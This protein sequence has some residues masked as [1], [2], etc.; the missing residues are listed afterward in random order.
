MTIVYYALPV[1]VFASLRLLFGNCWWLGVDVVLTAFEWL[2]MWL[3]KDDM[4]KD[5]T[6]GVQLVGGYM[7]S[8]RC[9]L[10]WTEIVRTTEYV[11]TRSGKRVARERVHH[12]Y[13]DCSYTG[14]TSVGGSSRGIGEKHFNDIVKKWGVMRRYEV[15][16]GDNIAGGSRE[17]YWYDYRD[18]INTDKCS[19]Y[20]RMEPIVEHRY[21]ENKIKNSNSIFRFERI[22]KEKAKELGL[23]DFMS[24]SVD[25]VLAGEGEV[26]EDVQH[27]F[28]VF[29]SWYAPR[30]GMRLFVLI[31]DANVHKVDI[32]DKQRAWWQ[33]GN[34]NEFVV[35]LG[36]SGG[37]VKWCRPWSWSDEPTLEA[38]VETWFVKNPGYDLMAFLRWLKKNYTLWKPK[39][40][41][42]FDY[43][44][45]DLTPEQHLKLLL[46]AIAISLA[47]AVLYVWWLCS[48]NEW[49]LRSAFL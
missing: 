4:K 32:A 1:I 45:V 19:G 36:V 39:D 12:E 10:P 27:A 6:Y 21:Y 8:V 17:S 3:M 28:N 16:H 33:G 23:Y 47:Y 35:C 34:P 38:E 37:E 14:Q 18:I 43:I 42:D 31:F 26:P 11:T 44:T 41:S 46:R 29:N 22:R 49:A 7:Q 24:F 25:T 40:L 15:I 9:N 30:V 5:L 20:R 2:A 13:H 48:F